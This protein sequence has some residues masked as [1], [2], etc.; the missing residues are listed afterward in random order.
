[1]TAQKPTEKEEFEKTILTKCQEMID[2]VSDDVGKL[3]EDTL[4]RINVLNSIL[5]NIQQFHTGGQTKETTLTEKILAFMGS[6]LNKRIT[7]TEIIKNTAQNGDGKGINADVDQTVA[8]EL[9][10]LRD[11]GEYGVGNFG[12]NVW[13]MVSKEAGKIETPSPA[14]ANS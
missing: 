12:K 13:M 6:N 10:K 2:K 4:S 8:D 7:I 14:K 11:A 5:T 1:M 3:R 9:I